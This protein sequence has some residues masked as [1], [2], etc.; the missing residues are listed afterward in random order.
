MGTF[1][2]NALNPTKSHPY[3]N[4]VMHATIVKIAPATRPDSCRITGLMLPPRHQKAAKRALWT[5]WPRRILSDRG[6]VMLLLLASVAVL[7]AG[8][9]IPRLTDRVRASTFD[10]LGSA[11]GILTIPTQKITQLVEHMTGLSDMSAD[12]GRLRQENAT[13]KQWYDRARQLEAENNSLRSLVKLANLPRTEYTT[14]RV[15]AESGGAFAQGI[16]VDAGSAKGIVRDIAAMTGEG[17]IGRVMVTSDDTAQ[18]ALLTDINSRIPVV[19]ENSRHRGVMAGDNSPQPVLMYLPDDAAVSVGERVLTSGMGGVFAPGLPIGVIVSTDQGR[20][21]V[22]PFADL[23]RLDFVQ[24]VN[25]GRNTITNEQIVKP[26]S[27][28][29]IVPQQGVKR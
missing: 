11:L 10:S 19:I 8:L 18:V 16:I 5:Y 17:V 2:S 27:Q 13:L 22:Q 25:F 4:N 28:K 14:A 1:L 6:T 21:R 9:A 23:R 15:I 24:L 26:V 7:I 20:V 12:L 29:T 3:V